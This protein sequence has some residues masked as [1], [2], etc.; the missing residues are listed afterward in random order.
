MKRINA[1]GYYL[2][3]APRESSGYEHMFSERAYLVQNIE[4]FMTY[5]GV[6]PEEITIYELR[7]MNERKE[8]KENEET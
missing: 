5:Y 6:E 4:N 8:K 3:L 7:E 2:L 1:H